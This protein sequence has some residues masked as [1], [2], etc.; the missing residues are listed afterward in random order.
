M[1]KIDVFKNNNKATALYIFSVD[2]KTKVVYIAV[3]RKVPNKSRTSF[4]HK[5]WTGAAGT[6]SKY[7][8]KWTN[9]GGGKNPGEHDLKAA[10]HELNEEANISEIMRPIDYRKHVH[11]EYLNKFA[12]PGTI[13]TLHTAF[14]TKSTS[15]F[16]FSMN[17]NIFFSVFPAYP[18]ARV[19]QR[20]V[21]SSKGEIDAVMSVHMKQLL[22]MQRKELKISKNNFFIS[23]FCRGMNNV[24]PLLKNTYTSF[25]N[26]WRGTH[27]KWT[28]DAVPR[29]PTEFK[30]HNYK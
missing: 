24:I 19:G 20:I 18:S 14:S 15:I 22:K 17:H 10:I 26:K 21:T 12:K 3:V 30:D 29:Q 7:F 5:V 13:M 6:K 25:Y 27:I 28:I 9:I 1:N 4:K 2:P 8:G 16:V 23:Y 11:I